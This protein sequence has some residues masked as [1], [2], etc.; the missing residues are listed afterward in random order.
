MTTYNSIAEMLSAGHVL[1]PGMLVFVL[2]DEELY[3]RVKSGMQQV[4][5][6]SY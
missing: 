5:L 2:E 6:V 3:I 1:D 4:P